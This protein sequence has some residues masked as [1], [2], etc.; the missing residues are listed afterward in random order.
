MYLLSGLLTGSFGSFA[1]EVEDAEVVE[2]LGFL[3]LPGSAPSDC[4][5]G[6]I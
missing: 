6:V 1:K 4:I 5:G 3:V 2:P